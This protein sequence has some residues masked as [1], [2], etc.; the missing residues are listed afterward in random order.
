MVCGVTMT[1]YEPPRHRSIPLLERVAQ[2]KAL[3]LSKVELHTV[4]NA[5]YG[6]ARDCGE[7][8]PMYRHRDIPECP[9]EISG[10]GILTIASIQEA[11]ADHFNLNLDE[12]LSYRRDVRIIIPRHVAIY[13]SK[14]LTNKSFTEVGLRF[15]G[16]DHST[17]IYAVRKISKLIETDNAL[18]DKITVIKGKLSP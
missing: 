1:S 11:V 12:L 9:P 8:S 10:P 13:L 14:I 16:M 3:N 18:A 5:I 4:L 2:A 17:I 6:S 15:G 7:L